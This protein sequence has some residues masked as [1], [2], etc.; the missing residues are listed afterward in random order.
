MEVL[1]KVEEGSR[2]LP[3][4]SYISVRV[5][6]IQKQTHYDP[7]KV[8]KFPK[9][10]RHGKLDVYQKIG[11]C[12]LLWEATGSVTH[13]VSLSAADGGTGSRLTVS[14][15]STSC[16]EA[17]TVDFQKAERSPDPA[18]KAKNYLHENGVEVLLTGAMRSLLKSMPDDPKSFLIDYIDRNS[19]A[20]KPHIQDVAVD[21]PV[22]GPFPA[23]EPFSSY[24]RAHVLP[25][26]TVCTKIPVARD[27]P[28]VKAALPLEICVEEPDVLQPT[29]VD[30]ETIRLRTRSELET[31]YHNG[32]LTEALRLFHPCV[33][34][35]SERAE[36]SAVEDGRLV[37]ALPNVG[38]EKEEDSDWVLADA[39]TNA[40]ER[41]PLEEVS[42]AHAGE[43]EVPKAMKNLRED[44]VLN[45]V[46]EI[47][48]ECPRERSRRVLENAVHD[49]RLDAVVQDVSSTKTVPEDSPR[50]VD[51]I[52]AKSA[53]LL[54]SAMLDGTLKALLSQ[55]PME[56]AEVV[57]TLEAVLEQGPT[58]RADGAGDLARLRAKSARLL[59]RALGDGTLAGIVQAVS[60]S[61]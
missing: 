16:G 60:H 10:R 30:V 32:K 56:G 38:G 11:T 9:A 27:A 4:D 43:V 25:S 29:P 40:S 57:G 35:A 48:V 46:Q 13:T 58:N 54:E 28:E 34:R 14:L 3:A 39:S 41:A 6:D 8:F 59:E 49:G 19:T 52:R 7:H 37:A 61:S 22:P 23:T 26:S 36:L 33:L 20:K 45:H 2:P 44:A 51:T 31:A 1:V 18:A 47:D 21:R 55:G 5:G 17:A 53:Y 12:D 50:D 42:D 24:Y 15:N